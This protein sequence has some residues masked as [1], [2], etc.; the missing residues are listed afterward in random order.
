MLNDFINVINTL[1]ARVRDHRSDLAENETRTRMALINPLLTALGWDTSDP[2]CV[3]AEYPVSGG[4]A[5]YALRNPGPTPAA[6]IEA[7]KL[8]ESLEPHREQMTRY[9]NMAGVKYAGLANGDRWE[10]YEVFRQ[11]SLDE[12]RILDLSILGDPPPECALKLLLLWRPNLELG[13]PV[14]ASEPILVEFSALPLPQTHDERIASMRSEGLTVAPSRGAVTVAPSRASP[15]SGAV[16]GVTPQ[17]IP[18]RWEHQSTVYQATLQPDGGIRLVDGSVNTPSG[19]VKKL[20]EVSRNGWD[21]WEYQDEQTGQW[22]AIGSLPNASDLRQFSKRYRGQH[23]VAP[24]LS[25][26]PASASPYSV[27]A[28]GATPLGIPIRWVSHGQSHEAIL[29]E[30]GHGRVWLDGQE[31][32]KPSRACRQLVPSRSAN[33]WSEWEYFDRQDQS[34]QPISRLRGLS[35]EEQARRA[36]ASIGVVAPPQRRQRRS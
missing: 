6:F 35:D 17:G 8:G 29:L 23:A 7:K 14:P 33:G 25:G 15:S 32:P 26:A 36:G 9:S 30:R 1:K 4:K 2:A 28:M 5:D 18:I 22:R 13:S 24:Q 19:A 10:L 21:V 34:S 11:A 16:A 31:F 12:R 3:M 20:A 27:A